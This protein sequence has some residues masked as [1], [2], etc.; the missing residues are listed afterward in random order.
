MNLRFLILVLSVTVLLL[1]YLA[2]FWD[3]QSSR[4]SFDNRDSLRSKFEVLASSGNSSCSANF[5][6][7]INS[8]RGGDRLQ[9]SCCS[10]MSWHRYKE[11]V[12]GL[13]KYKKIKEIPTDP[14]DIDAR[15]AKEMKSHYNDKLNAGQQKA[16]DFAMQNSDEKGPC[17]CKCWR[18]YVYGGLAKYL[19][20]NYDFTGEQITEVW[21][22]S[23]GC[24]GEG[25]HVNHAT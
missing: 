25:D 12:N 18:W 13:R 17:C 6:D 3:G 5:T 8:M 4:F 21:N 14:Y 24:G 9:G 2:I 16:Y 20:Q 1:G 7:S 15:L 23:D 10:S 22:L 19:I 11:Q